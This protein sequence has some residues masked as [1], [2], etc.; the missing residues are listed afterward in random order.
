MIK[1]I[2]K[3]IALLII[4]VALYQLPSLNVA[5]QADLLLKSYLSLLLMVA[6]F[7]LG[8]SPFF[9]AVASLEFCALMYNLLLFLSYLMNISALHHAFSGLMT[10][11]FCC[12]LAAIFT[13]AASVEY[14]HLQQLPNR[15]RAGGHGNKGSSL[16]NSNLEGAK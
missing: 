3:H 2:W 10:M 15:L 11:I 7:C 6:C 9:F 13:G 1:R 4:T 16:P 12:Q 5:W 14:R 8:L